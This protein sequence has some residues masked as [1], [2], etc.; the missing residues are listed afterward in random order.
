MKK[1]V[2]KC[3]IIII[4]FFSALFVVGSIMNKGNSDMTMEMSK[5]S[6]PVI[7]VKYAGQIINA[8]H[9]YSEAMEVSHMRENI[10]PLSTGRKVSMVIDTYNRGIRNIAFEVR[11]VDG[12]RLIENTQVEDYETTDNGIELSFGLKDLIENN[13][14]YALI[15]ILTLDD[16]T[17]VRYYTRVIN[18]EEYY[19]SDKLDYVVEFSRKTFNKEAAKDLVKYLESNAEGDN[20]TF[21]NVNIHSSFYQVTWGNLDVTRET[22]PE[23]TIKELA[24]QTGS[25]VLDYY[26]SVQEGTEQVYYKVKEYYRV[27]Y[28]AERIYLLDFERSMD[29]VYE[30][31]GDVYTKNKIMMGITSR[32]SSLVESDG[33]NVVAFVTG[34]RLYSYNMVDNKMAYLFGFYDKDNMDARTLYDK[35]NIRILNVDEAG[36]VTFLVYGYMNR[37]RHEG[38][39]GIS[40]YFYD[41]MVNTVEEMVY[42][43]SNSSEEILMTEVE[44]LA[45][46]NRNSLLYLME[47]NQIYG[48]HAMNRTCEVIAGNLAE[49]SYKVSDSN[50]MIVWQDSG[51]AYEGQELV[52]MNL[53]TGNQK[54]IRA[55]SDEVIAPI[56]FMGEDLIYGIAK[57]DDI[58]MDYT[59]NIIFPMYCIK[60]ENEVEG[61]LMVYE[62][63]NVYITAGEVSE[64]QILL[65]R[66]EKD[67]DGQYIEIK[68]DQIMNAEIPS[69]NKNS[70]ETVVTE[71]YEKLTQIAL[72]SEI[73]AA[74]M[75]HLTPKEVL[76][77]GGRNIR[78][79]EGEA[80]TERYY[81]YGK[82]GID[83]IFMD[84]GRAVNLAYDISGTVIN[85]TGSCVWLKGNRNQKNQIMAIS[86]EQET[87]EKNSLTICLDTMMAYEGVIRNSEYMLNRGDSVMSI[88]EENL[89]EAQV[90]DLT[91]CSLDAVLYYVNQDIP[92]L[93]M[94]Q[95]GTAVLL[96]GFNE[97]NTVV[98]NPETGTVYK[99][100]MND[101]KEWFEQNGNCFIT[102]IPN[103]K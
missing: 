73:D 27:R 39:V 24:K 4:V 46:I 25:F 76:F 77:E 98:M 51:S 32:E 20:S 97:M 99:V 31:T 26:V 14:E 21:G 91:G 84:E 56:G 90:L 28:T 87:E 6:Y 67:E 50:K 93:V 47:D 85:E 34:N 94:M 102:Y 22:Q 60:I 69:A 71:K 48:I 55:G 64:N 70:I 96:I 53:N 75:K 44:Q 49:G 81:V 65:S 82:Y 41:S 103:E 59:G 79:S 30:E 3:A 61:V 66:V 74:A 95:D 13:Q 8:M 57:K 63:S 7:S 38:E 89:E 15:V 72:K 100:G 54:S 18:P 23:I 5:A 43:P 17:D 83:G 16:G 9:G 101:S 78:L 86:G 36:N 58:M 45:Y 33:G 92:V 35:H 42:I 62:Q 68:D 80:L 12:N 88:L 2:I 37:G 19:T 40:A 52:L 11:S 29:Q 10:T 1:M